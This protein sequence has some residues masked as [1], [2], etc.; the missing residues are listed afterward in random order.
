MQ[1][2]Q[3]ASLL[4]CLSGVHSV[5]Y[6]ELERALGISGSGKIRQLK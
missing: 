6:S 3:V 5:S 2:V 4:A 1:N